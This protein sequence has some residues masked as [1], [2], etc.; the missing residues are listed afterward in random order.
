MQSKQSSGS[1]TIFLFCTVLSICF[2]QDIES[3]K[4]SWF[5]VTFC[6][7]E[8][9]KYILSVLCVCT[10][11]PRTETLLDTAN[12]YVK[13]S[14]E[15]YQDALSLLMK[16]LD[17]LDSPEHKPSGLDQSLWEH[18]CLARRNKMESEELVCKILY[19]ACIVLDIF[20]S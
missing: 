4:H 7:R 10:R 9:T 13:R 8:N 5:F 6:A 1:K 20:E 3:T 14:V 11:T 18:F 19:C 17:E 16:T 15:D 2:L 12:P